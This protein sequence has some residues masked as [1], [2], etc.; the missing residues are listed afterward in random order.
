MKLTK[1]N[2][3]LLFWIL[4]ILG[5]VGMSS[6][7]LIFPFGFSKTYMLYSFIV[8]S[9]IGIV[10]TSIFRHYLNNNIDIEVFGKRSIINLVVSFFGCSLL[11][12]FLLFTT[13]EIYE[14]YIGRT[15]TEIK[16]IKENIGVLSALFNT[17]I[18]V[19]GWTIIYFAIKFVINANKNRLESL[20]LNA[21][22]REA[23]L[24][25]LKGQVNPHFMFNSLNNI[26]G[27]MLEDVN[28]SREM[29][30]KLSEMLQYA[31]SKNTVDAIALREEVDMVDN[32][33]ALAKIQMEDRLHYEKEIAAESLTIMIPPMIIQLLVENAAKHG[34]SN[35]KNGGIILLQTIVTASELQIVVKNTGKLSIS[36]NSTKLGLKN[37]RQ[38]LRLL[39]GPK[40]QFTLEEIENEVIATIKIPTL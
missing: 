38:R 25:T 29:I 24:N 32:Y 8:G 22:L 33:I 7:I 2:K 30:T 37:I 5:W 11:Y 9:A 27:L 21:T 6:L 19:F 36:E 18:T 14:L 15:A 23:Q 40:G 3:E 4:Q 35:L 39:Y 28:K 20:E 17:M 26:R 1:T 13:E 10:S 12:Y 16:W 31:L 34:I